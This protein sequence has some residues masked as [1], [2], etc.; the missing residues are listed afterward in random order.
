MTTDESKYLGITVIDGNTE[1]HIPLDKGRAATVKAIRAM[2]NEMSG[3]NVDHTQTIKR[4]Y[5]KLVSIVLY[6]GHWWWLMVS[7]YYQ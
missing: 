2:V 1:Y 3:W 7:Y 6:S 5:D 4:S